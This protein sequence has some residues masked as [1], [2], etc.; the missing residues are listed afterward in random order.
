MNFCYCLGVYNVLCLRVLLCSF[1][2]KKNKKRVVQKRFRAWVGEFRP[3][4]PLPVLLR[5]GGSRKNQ[6]HHVNKKVNFFFWFVI[7]VRA[8]VCV[9]V[10]TICKKKIFKK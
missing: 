9:C 10:C 8:C 3:L 6:S 4:G 7:C 2:K 1:V 5:T